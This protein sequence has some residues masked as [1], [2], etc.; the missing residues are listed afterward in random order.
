[1]KIGTI[2]QPNQKGQIVIPKEYRDIL[3][4]NLNMPLNL[5]LRG[6]GLYLYP[7]QEVIRKADS[8]NSYLNILQKTKGKWL[9][10]NW[11]KIRKKRRK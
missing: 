7:I 5:V 8:E 9:E 4:L 11:P 3:E 10:A 1:M 6:K 2:I